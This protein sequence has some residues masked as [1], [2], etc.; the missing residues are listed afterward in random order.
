MKINRVIKVYFSPTGT[1]EKVVAAIADAISHKLVC[2]TGCFDFT[3]PGARSGSDSKSRFPVLSPSDLVIFGC[4]TYAGRLPNLLLKYLRTIQGN[5]AFA[6]PVVTFG[7]R[8]FD[9]SLI[10][11]RDLLEE[12]GFHTIA[13]A[14]C[15]CEHSFSTTLGAGRPDAADLTEIRTFAGQITEK[16]GS[17]ESISSPI[18]VPG[19]PAEKDHG[20]YYQPRDR[21]GVFI[22]IR[23]VKPLTDREKCLAFSS[24]DDGC[25]ICA[26]V[27]PMGAIAPSDF[28]QVPGIC[29][30]CGACIK[31]CPAQAKYYEDPGYLYHKAELE[32]MYTRRAVN[33]FFL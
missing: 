5:G 17:T 13:G 1:T 32:E 3:L 25:G 6:V 18:P 33:H 29:I 7:N 4:P 12:Q 26:A 22:D 19:V 8:N 14:S 15:S 24:A 10:E 9:N 11:L 23:K 28:T 2:E 31:K 30:K 16:I 20:G 27:C 21:H